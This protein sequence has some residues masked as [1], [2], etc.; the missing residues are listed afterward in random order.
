MAIPKAPTSVRRVGVLPQVQSYRSQ[1]GT[2]G[3]EINSV[4]SAGERTLDAYQRSEMEEA[5]TNHIL[6]KRAEAEQEQQR[7][8]AEREARLEEQRQ[9][10]EERRID[11][12]AA[13]RVI[14]FDNYVKARWSGSVEFNP[15]GSQT[16]VPGVT[17]KTWQDMDREKMTPDKYMGNIIRDA[18]EQDFY[19][20]APEDVRK[21]IE[22][23]LQ[24]KYKAYGVAAY[25][26]NMRNNAAKIQDQNARQEAKI[27]SDLQSVEGTTE[28]EFEAQSNFAAL[29]KIALKYG[30]AIENPDILL[31]SIVQDGNAVRPVSLNDLTLKG[32][33]DR[34]DPAYTRMRE[35]YEA[36]I[37]EQAKNRIINL[38]KFASADTPINGVGAEG[39]LDRADKTRENLKAWGLLSDSEYSAFGA[40]IDDAK[41][42][43]ESTR[44]GVRASRHRT[45]ANKL[46]ED[47]KKRTEGMD[48]TTDFIGAKFEA[49]EDYVKTLDALVKRDAI[50]EK[51]AEAYKQAYA[52]LLS[53]QE[54]MRSAVDRYEKTGKGGVWTDRLTRDGKT[55]KVFEPERNGA[56][57][58]M[59]PFYAEKYTKAD[60]N[61]ETPYF[62][63]PLQ[64]MEELEYD[65]RMG[66]ITLSFYN[67]QMAKMR[68]FSDDKAKQAFVR[69]FGATPE[70]FP[71]KDLP[72]FE[73]L[74]ISTVPRDIWAK[75]SEWDRTHGEDSW[76]EDIS[77]NGFWES[78]EEKVTPEQQM[79]ICE[80]ILSLAREGVDPTEAIHQYLA[81]TYESW[82][83]TDLSHRLDPNERRGGKT[84]REMIMN[85]VRTGEVDKSRE[86]RESRIQ[87]RQQ[88]AYKNKSL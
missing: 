47:F 23:H 60:R 43:C 22:K 8:Q 10:A 20:D 24:A 3:K 46:A 59:S 75:T 42:K 17:S 39:L 54:Y 78:G 28:A 45:N 74:G 41:R 57:G 67:A 55:V 11:R 79:Q 50:D 62:N 70:M 32:I 65:Y 38:S 66:N 86:G 33:A 68:V 61:G 2:I 6:A 13:D 82:A 56:A 35:D 72:A 19:R 7:I 21:A 9:R 25:Q 5:R 77:D 52:S 37:K 48:A 88:D 87:K 15:D 16:V 36:L 63:N 80:M 30:S 76:E 69:I 49:K 51:T 31:D 14:S 73:K 84:F 44:Q 40:M 85:S 53:R 81:P 34:D 58:E 29:Q 26:L 12:D 64:G 71:D 18:K 27:N 83:A 1:W 4:L